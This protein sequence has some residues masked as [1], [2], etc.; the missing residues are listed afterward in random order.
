MSS[1]PCQA[2]IASV[3]LSRISLVKR[4]S[5]VTIVNQPQR[6]T[7]PI[8]LVWKWSSSYFSSATK[9]RQLKLIDLLIKFRRPK[10]CWTPTSVRRVNQTFGEIC[11]DSSCSSKTCRC[12]ASR[13][14]VTQL[15][16]LP[17]EFRTF[18]VVRKLSSDFLSTPPLKFRYIRRIF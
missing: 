12:D 2:V 7:R 10:N 11:Q 14:L 4:S 18:R 8:F 6:Y 16:Y 17:C 13:F 1:C 5:I 3:K 15:S 9:M